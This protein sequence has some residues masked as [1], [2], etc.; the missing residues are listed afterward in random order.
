MLEKTEGTIQN[1]QSTE[2]GNTG[3]TK[4]TTVIFIPFPVKGYH[5]LLRDRNKQYIKITLY[6]VL[7]VHFPYTRP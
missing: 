1:G 5:L 3:Y 7:Y 6:V 4:T 2:T